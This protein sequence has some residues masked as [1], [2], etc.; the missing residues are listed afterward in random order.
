[1]SRVYVGNLDS[2][3]TERELE[4]EF[5][6]Y[7]VLRSIWVARKPLRFAFI[8][9]E[10][11]RDADDAIRA[12]NGK[13]GWRVELSRSSSGGGG[14]RTRGVEEM[15]CYECGEPGHFA[16]ECR[17]RIGPGGLGTGGHTRSPLHSSPNH[18]RSA[19]GARRHFLLMRGALASAFG[20]HVTFTHSLQILHVHFLF[21]TLQVHIPMEEVGLLFLLTEEVFLLWCIQEEVLI[22]LHLSIMNIMHLQLLM[23]TPNSILSHQLVWSRSPVPTRDRQHVRSRSRSA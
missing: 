16:R 4:D 12:L 6:V 10:D 15:K 2:R 22:N 9:F 5:R 14:V 7:G 21:L 8:E 18:R 3:A 19:H 17:L 13:C 20:S 23:G 1:M 11:Q